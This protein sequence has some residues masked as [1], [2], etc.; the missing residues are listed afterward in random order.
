MKIMKVHK[1][2]VDPT[3]LDVVS[4]TGGNKM[5]TDVQR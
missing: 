4:G 2:E 1:S 3:L 5:L